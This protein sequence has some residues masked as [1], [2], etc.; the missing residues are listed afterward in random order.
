MAEKITTPICREAVEKIEK[1]SYLNIVV[2]GAS[3]TERHIPGTHW[4]DVLELG[5]RAAYGRKFH[6]INAGECGGN[7]RGGLARFDRDVA[8]FSPGIVI[9]TFAAN[10]YSLAVQKHVPAEEFSRNL[11]LIAEKI[12]NMDA[13]PL[14][15][16]YYKPHFENMGPELE[17]LFLE[18][19]QIIRET[20]V[21]K[22]VFLVD[23][24]RYFDAVPAETRLYKLLRDPMH[25]NEYG[26]T[27]IG[28]TL[29]HHLGIDPR[30]IPCRE[31]L[32]P[33]I[34]LYDSIADQ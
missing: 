2:F 18:Y 33:A 25:V 24:Y 22:K 13:V 32:L 1:S 7:T 27:F 4:S 16:T 10:D 17:K 28:V 26:N 14:L 29:L 5:I 9:V 8:A 31:S 3:N 21:R 30:I 15:Q 12:R 19:M 34:E 20:A 6:M 23:Q 11:E